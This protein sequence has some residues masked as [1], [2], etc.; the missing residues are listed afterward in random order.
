MIFR[1]FFFVVFTVLIGGSTK[2]KAQEQTIPAQEIIKKTILLKEGTRVKN[3]EF[4]AYNK[5]IVTANPELIKGKID[6]IFIT[7]RRKKTLK[8]IDSSEYN[9]KKIIS[10]QHLYQT[11]KIS[12]Y[13]IVNRQNKEIILATRMAG[14]KEPIYEYFALHLQPLTGYEKKFTL[15]E[16]DF[17]SPI[18]KRGLTQYDYTRLENTT[19]NQRKIIIIAF[20]PKASNKNNKLSGK[21]YIDEEQYNLAKLEL[22][23][24]GIINVKAV[25]DY[26]YNEEKQFWLPL[27][28]ALT[29]KKGKNKT[30]IKIFGQLITFDNTEDLF[31][32]DVKKTVS[33]YIEIKSKTNYYKLRT[34]SIKKIFRDGISVE[35]SEKSTEKREAIWQEHLQDTIDLRCNPTYV[36]IDSLVE[37][38]RIENK[39]TIGRKIIKGYYPL[40]F[41]DFDLRYLF[42]YNNYEG[43]RVGL[44]G[45]TNEKL[46]KDYKIEGYLAYGA[47]DGFFKGMIS[48]V[49][50]LHK[51]SE[52]W[53]GV[54]YKDDVSEI[55]NT[56]FEIDKKNFKIYDPRPF[57]ISTFYNHETWRGFVESKIIPKTES[58]FQITQS[59]IEPK[60][61]YSF[62]N[63]GKLYTD[64]R[65][66]LVTASVQW[67][68]FSNYMQ[69]PRGK[70]EIEKRYPKFTFQFT[71]SLPGLWRNNFDFG[72][73]DF[74]FDLQKKFN[75]N[76]KILFLAEAQY[77]F[78]EVPL[79]HLYNHSPNNL[80]KD[81]I[82]KRITFAGRD[83]FETMYFNEFFSNKLA[84]F[85][86]EHQFPKLYISRQLK[87]LFSLVTR[88]GIGDL[89]HKERHKDF[90]FKT[91]EKG[92][93]ESGFEL[94]QLFKIV[95]FTAFY[96]Y[97]PNQ[98]PNFEDNIA[99]K[100]SVQIDL[101]FNN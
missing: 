89:N 2:I 49:V 4:T 88:Y 50:R 54:S 100:L 80:N 68:P 38:K 28:S 13:S 18:S 56:N 33:D 59:Y 32:P 51:K 1:K 101:G 65:T 61:N 17:V 26:Q 75:S 71:K 45:V 42:K 46:S 9:F 69:T 77:A 44:G 34:D 21:L 78:G 40:S 72:K 36:S 37:A 25:H 85:Q 5:V 12:Q 87:P 90:A 98:L 57:N 76:H 39:I 60:F 3:F 67:N 97:G 29:I 73:I 66:T 30:P 64:F 52:T 94:N 95:G 86:L 20:K 79:T 14:F 55:A 24:E 27:N 31:D 91:L 82:L 6:S 63:H 99:L 92:F 23:S 43:I 53:L 58:V 16:K 93:M 81:K 11:E 83:S 41:F 47:K 96:R 84:F 10:K 8:K 19:L 7:K 22:Q 62:E 35:V 74:R 70:I 15:A 48:N